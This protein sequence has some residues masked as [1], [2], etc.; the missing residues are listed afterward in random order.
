MYAVLNQGIVEEVTKSYESAIE[1]LQ[2]T[3]GYDWYL[4]D[5]AV[6]DYEDIEEV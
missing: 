4:Y 5:Y 3:H 6:I 2:E 1:Y